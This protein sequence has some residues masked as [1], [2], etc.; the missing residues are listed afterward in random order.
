MYKNRLA[1]CSH[2]DLRAVTSSS[3]QETSEE[4]EPCQV[5]LSVKTQKGNAH[6]DLEILLRPGTWAADDN[7]LSTSL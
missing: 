4:L 2:S 7:C 6:F 3:H 5:P 1:C